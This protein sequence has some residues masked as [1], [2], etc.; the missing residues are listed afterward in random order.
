ML[1]ILAEVLRTCIVS[2]SL[3]DSSLLSLV[4]S[5]QTHAAWQGSSLHDLI[6]PGFYFLVGLAAALSLARRARAGQTGLALT[7][8]VLLRSAF[9]VTLG[10]A[11]VA[12]H[13]REW[14]WTFTDT[15]TQIGLAYPFL[16]L[17]AR[18]SKRVWGVVLAGILVGYWLWF[19]LTPVPAGFPADG[20]TAHWQKNANAAW[21]FDVWFL[22]RLPGAPPHSGYPNGLTTLNFIPSI[23]TMILGLF[24]GDRLRQQ[25][26]AVET[27]RWFIATG[28]VLLSAGWLLGALGVCPVVK[29]IWTPSWVLFSGGWSFLLLAAFYGLVDVWGLRRPAFPLTVIGMNSLVAYVM[30]H[31]YPALAFNALRRV[32]GFRVFE[33][34]GSAYAP[35]AYGAAVIVAYWLVLAALYRARIFVRI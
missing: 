27:L 29:A 1:L 7:G 34:F 31:L 20:F 24:A 30:S 9:L 33:V 6:Q 18:Q 32:L 22:S 12:V 19:A 26:P 15:L 11:L 35:L 8:H 14:S 13:P 3:P 16:V 2:A 17:T 21:Q 10:M 5:Q 28:V 4:C 25:R 23:A